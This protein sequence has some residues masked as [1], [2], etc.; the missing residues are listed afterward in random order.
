[1]Y[2]FNYSLSR[3]LVGEVV[4]KMNSDIAAYN[5]CT[6]STLNF[7]QSLIFI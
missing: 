6:T 3:S 1:M 5:H 4:L 7:R 2:L